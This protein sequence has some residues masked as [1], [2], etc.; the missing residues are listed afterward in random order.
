MPA[1]STTNDQDSAYG[2]RT[3]GLRGDVRYHYHLFFVRHGPS[4]GI[5]EQR[6]AGGPRR[7][8]APDLASPPD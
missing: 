1:I 8:H 7:M 5:E 2:I 3:V 6:R 4:Y